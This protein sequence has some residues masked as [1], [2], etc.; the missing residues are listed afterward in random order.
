MYIMSFRWHLGGGGVRGV[1]VVSFECGWPVEPA[2]QHL[3][4]FPSNRVRVAVGRTHQHAHVSAC[5]LAS[6]ATSASNVHQE[7]EIAHGEI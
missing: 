3:L 5:A 2:L 6:E 1:G 7:N 4:R